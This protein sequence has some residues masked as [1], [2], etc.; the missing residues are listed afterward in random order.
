MVDG[1]GNG[2][3]QLAFWVVTGFFVLSISTLTSSVIG[4]D[5]MRVSEDKNLSDRMY[6]IRRETN[7]KLTDILCEIASLKAFLSKNGTSSE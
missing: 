6:E 4:N 3:W 7:S 5:R 2:K 1:N